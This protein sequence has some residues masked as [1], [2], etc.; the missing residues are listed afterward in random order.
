MHVIAR[1]L[2][3]AYLGLA[4][5]GALVYVQ[6]TSNYVNV[7]D[8]SLNMGSHLSVVGVQLNW[9]GSVNDSAVVYVRFNV[10]NPGNIDILVM[11]T[12][13][14]LHMDDPLDPRSVYDADKL[15][16]T[17]IQPGGFNLG[18]EQGVVVHP[19]Q[20]RTLHMATTVESGTSRMDRLDRPD[21]NGLYHPLIW[22]PRIVYT[23]VDFDLTNVA[24]MV[25]FY[26]SQGV[27]PTG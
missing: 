6:T 15:R 17:E 3:V 26:E 27:R 21:G 14:V 20:T 2:A 9:T 22:L 18:R 10:T 5:F 25:P 7:A 8:V 4:L 13:F 11:S 23:F 24:Y 19:G 1:V 16:A 12:D